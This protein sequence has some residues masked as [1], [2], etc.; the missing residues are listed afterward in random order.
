MPGDRI[1]GVVTPGKGVVV[2]TIDCEA[3]GAATE[4]PDAWLNLSWEPDAAR[5]GYH[6]ASIE[7]RSQNEPGALGK[8]STLIGKNHGNI[9]N[10]KL[11]ERTMRVFTMLIDLEVQDVKH[12]TEIIAALRTLT[13]VE[14]V[15]RV[16]S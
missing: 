9:T 2:H 14:T 11:T 6:L 13:V 15:D 8:I 4:D 16:R 10:L 1:V 3:L 12:L 7:V 5:H